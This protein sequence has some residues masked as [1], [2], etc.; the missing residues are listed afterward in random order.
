MSTQ[1]RPPKK[2]RDYLSKTIAA[3]AVAILLIAFG[4]SNRDDVPIDWLVT[5][6]KTP[7]IIVIVVSAVLGAILGALGVRRGSKR[8]GSRDA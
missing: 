4:L 8:A 2:E 6:T 5:T 3:I 1:E 7:L